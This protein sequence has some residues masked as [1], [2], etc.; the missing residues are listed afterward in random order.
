MKR[1]FLQLWVKNGLALFVFIFCTQTG[2]SQGTAQD[3]E[4]A[5]TFDARTANLLFGDAIK[6]QWTETGD[7]FWFRRTT[8]PKRSEYVLVETATGAMAPLFDPFLLSAALAQDCPTAKINRQN[9]H[10]TQLT[11]LPKEKALTFNFA[12]KRW[13]WDLTTNALTQLKTKPTSVKPLAPSRSPRR[14]EKTG[15]ETE[16]VFANASDEPLRLFWLDHEG[17]RIPYGEI[18]PQQ[19]RS[20]HTFTGHIWLITDKNKLTWGFYEAEPGGSLATL[21]PPTETTESVETT[22]DSSEESDGPNKKANISP[23]KHWRVQIERF[24]L[25]LE[26]LLD[27]TKQTLT[28]DATQ[29]DGFRGRVAWSP[30]STRFVV[31]RVIWSKPREVQFIESSPTDQLQPKLHTHV[32]RKPGDKL[33]QPF[34]WIFSVA[35]DGTPPVKLETSLFANPFT[36]SGQLDFVWSP[37]NDEVYFHY[38]QRGHQCYR[39]LAANAQTGAVRTIVDEK[40]E[41]FIAWN[42]KTWRHWL[43]SSGELVWISERSGWNHLYLYDI[44][45]GRIKNAITQGHWVVREVLRVDETAR[46]VW[47]LA[48]GLLP[49][50]DPYYTQLCRVNLD[51][52]GFT[53]LSEGDGNHTAEFAPGNQYFIDTW[54]RVDQPPIIELRRA[55]DGHRLAT[56]SRG[57]ATALLAKGW[58]VPERFTAKGRDGKTDIYGILIKPSHFDPAKSYPVIEQIYAGPHGAFVPKAFNRLV[59]QHELAELGFIIVQIDGMGTNHRGKTFHNIAWKNLQ[60][61]GFPDRIAWMKAAAASR[62]WMDLNRV[63]IYGGSAGGQNAMRAVLDHADFYKAAV[64]DCGCH[65]NRMDK[66][67]WNEQWLSWPVDD[68]YIRASNLV[69]APKLG[70]ALLLLVG[71]MDTNVDPAST[72][73]IVNALVKADKDFEYLV[74]P[75]GGHGSSRSPHA[76]RRLMD[77][78]VRNL[79]GTK[80]R[81]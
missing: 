2:F 59:S 4:R 78:F 40:S 28:T 53:V 45:T 35:R 42:E 47:F 31:N 30:D 63:G 3:Y 75:G 20:Q 69:D 52:T 39:I 19:S 36:E 71:E 38:N 34:P 7:Q 74:I 1:H 18:A 12:M 25:I 24:N 57:D 16:I 72:T 67:W 79:Y 55:A 66:I 44:A 27:G 15:E 77:F 65:D 9:L 6:P 73:Q 43:H 26:N 29:A 48:S 80:P 13:R 17:K 37:K 21:S 5:K 46:Q 14:S 56:L 60:D 33:P 68:S 41:T 32:Y 51:G 62:P 8:G 76:R 61:A 49:E 23:D 81:S 22:D 11:F 70:G 50:Q 54:S 58:S 10:L 64:A